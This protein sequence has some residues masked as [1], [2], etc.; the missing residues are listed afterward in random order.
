MDIF[1]SDAI[2][3]AAASVALWALLI[4]PGALVSEAMERLAPPPSRTAWSDWAPLFGLTLTPLLFATVLRLVGA[5]PAAG[6][7]LALAALALALARRQ[8]RLP[9]RLALL[10]ALAW[11][12]YCLALFGDLAID[13]R[14]YQSF[15][16]LDLVKHAAIIREIAD[17]GLPMGDPFFLRDGAV[18]YYHYFY[19]VPA[20][21]HRMLAAVVDPRMAFVGAAFW[22]GALFPLLLFNLV[23]NLGWQSGSSARLYL[24]C[25]GACMISGLDLIGV[26]LRSLFT[27]F[28]EPSAHWWDEDISFVPNSASWV[29]HHLSAVMAVFVAITVLCGTDARGSRTSRLALTGVAGLGFASAFGLSTWIAIGAAIVLA[30]TIIFTKPRGPWL[31]ALLVAGIVALLASAPQLAEVISGRSYDR[32]PLGF[33]VRDPARLGFVFYALLP[34]PAAIA[35]IVLVT[36]L[37]WFLQFGAFA[38]GTRLFFRY[39][40]LDGGSR[41]AAVLVVSA[42]TALVL[43]LTV[44]SNIINNDFGWRTIWFT[45]VPVMVWTVAAIGALTARGAALGAFWVAAALGLMVP[46]YNLAGAR[47]AHTAVFSPA[48]PG[49]EMAPDKAYDLRDAY[50]WA[51]E[52][53]PDDAVL[54]HNASAVRRAFQFGLYGTQRVAVADRE[55]MLFGAGRDEVLR[56]VDGFGDIFLGLAPVSNAAALGATHLVVTSDD[57]L[58]TGAP[59][60]VYRNRSACIVAVPRDG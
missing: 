10:F 36:P 49:R 58:W 39:A 23:R 47:L 19:D 18:G 4:L 27:G 25:C 24:L 46:V 55:A 53:L 44:R 40:R 38:L 51:S 52:N 11:W 16:I 59:P 14:L 5:G 48:P 28:L 8:I 7:A 54:Q 34:H 32:P 45:A 9:S 56:R 13:G 26:G 50:L 12:L 6:V 20:I 57:D 37:V 30:A 41:L 31:L 22:V 60:C 29:P 17:T 3:F 21:L 42:V 33:W 1:L 43:N 2:G 35:A 15:L